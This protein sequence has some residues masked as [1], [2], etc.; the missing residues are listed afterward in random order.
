M[1]I[2]VHKINLKI[3]KALTAG[4]MMEN[5]AQLMGYPIVIH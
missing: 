5:L 3:L 1:D 4:Q 2:T